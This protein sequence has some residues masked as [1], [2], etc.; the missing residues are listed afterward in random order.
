MRRS[1]LLVFGLYLLG[2]LIACGGSPTPPPP[3]PAALGYSNASLSGTFVFQ[4][5]GQNIRGDVFSAV[6]V[7]TTDGNGTITAGQQDSNDLFLGVKQAAAFT[8]SYTIGTDGRGQAT[9][10]YSNGNATTFR[11]VLTSSSR[12][13]LIEISNVENANG[14]IE[15]QDATALG[16]LNGNY[17]LHLDGVDA[18]SF[19]VSQVGLLTATGASGSASLLLDE[20]F[21]GAFTQQIASTTATFSL[22]GGGRGLLQ[23]VTSTGGANGTGG[24]SSYVFYVV[25]STR[26]E[27]LELDRS[28]QLSGAA[29]GQTGTFTTASVNGSYVYAIDGISQSGNPISEAGTFTLN[30]SGGITL[31]LED[32]IENG[33][34]NTLFPF[35]GSYSVGNNGRVAGQFNGSGRTVAFVLWFSSPQKAAI[36]TTGGSEVLVESGPVAF[37]PALPT[38]ATLNG[39]YSLRLSGVGTNGPLDIS[40][41]NQANGQGSF[42]GLFDFNQGGNVQIGATADGSY[43]FASGRGSGAIGTIPLVFYPADGNTIYMMSTDTRR[44]LIGSLETQH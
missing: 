29:D 40:G 23:F 44:L 13:R 37:Q 43:S 11:F 24:A 8:G 38:N 30:G 39:N 32:F 31:G 27:L 41:Q 14:L 5:S 21:D 9:F 42:T 26:L 4:V 19:P 15:Q 28:P 18:N 33:H 7:F 16:S 10:N 12:A 17:V 6:G 34:L 36:L 3:A 1:V 2:N 25:N 22:Q 35:S 20:N